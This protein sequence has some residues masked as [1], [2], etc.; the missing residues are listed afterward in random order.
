MA[1]FQSEQGV[2]QQL[3]QALLFGQNQPQAD[4][5]QIAANEGMM[6]DLQVQ[7]VLDQFG[8]RRHLDTRGRP[9][10]PMGER[11]NPTNLDIFYEQNPHMRPGEF[12]PKGAKAQG[13]RNTQIRTG[14]LQA[15]A[16]ED[17]AGATSAAAAILRGALEKRAGGEGSEQAPAP[18]PQPIA[19]PN[20]QL[21]DEVAMLKRSLEVLAS[22][23]SAQAVQS[24]A[25]VAQEAPTPVLGLND[26]GRA[27]VFGP[28]RPDPFAAGSFEGV[29]SLAPGSAAN[30]FDAQPVQY[31]PSTPAP[32]FDS[33]TPATVPSTAASAFAA[34]QVAP[35]PIDIPAFVGGTNE[36]FAQNAPDNLEGLNSVNREPFAFGQ[37]F[38][39]R[40]LQQ[41]GSQLVP[42]GNPNQLF[43][44]IDSVIG[45]ILA[46]PGTSTAAANRLGADER[47]NAAR[48]FL[49]Q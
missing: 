31:V 2:A 34:D 3:L 49:N 40:Y 13:R 18:G 10:D 1:L 20:Q 45:R 36:P 38:D 8:P 14:D 25:P 28:E 47:R 39:P 46:P 43:S 4:L 17:V 48:S 19:Q 41:V 26:P 12:D 24:A 30:V 42:A 44:N 9:I 6:N 7:R 37:A 35:V 21:E 23:P 33:A 29:G 32:V 16:A 27:P 22:E 11:K 15:Q 5:N